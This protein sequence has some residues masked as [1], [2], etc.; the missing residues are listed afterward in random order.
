MLLHIHKGLGRLSVSQLIKA[1]AAVNNANG[2][3]DSKVNFVMPAPVV[4][5]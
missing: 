3:D 5:V 4:S 2:R 1:N